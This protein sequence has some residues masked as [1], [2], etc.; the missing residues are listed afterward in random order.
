MHFDGKRDIYEQVVARQAQRN[1]VR[2]AAAVATLPA[3]AAQ[4]EAVVR[5]A[6]DSARAHIIETGEDEWLREYEIA[7]DAFR[8]ANGDLLRELVQGGMKADPSCDR[9]S[10]LMARIGRFIS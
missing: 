4:V 9:D 5:Y 10:E 2:L 3:Y 1:K 7:G 6:L 8:K